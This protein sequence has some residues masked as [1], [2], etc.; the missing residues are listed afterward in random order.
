MTLRSSYTL[1][2]WV[3]YPIRCRSALP[4]ATSPNAM[5]VPEVSCWTPTRERISVDLPQ[6]LG[7]SSPVT[8]PCSIVK[9]IPL[10]TSC[11]PRRTTRSR[12]STALF[13]MR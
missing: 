7:P 1:A 8:L 2:A 12:T 5:T 9:P 6:P 11:P 10:R 3:T 13:I 4:P